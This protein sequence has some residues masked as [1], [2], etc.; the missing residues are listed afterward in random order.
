MMLVIDNIIDLHVDV[1]QRTEYFVHEQHLST[2]ASPLRSAV[3][4]VKGHRHPSIGARGETAVEVVY[5]L[6]YVL[7]YF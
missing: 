3:L 4:I 6:Q 1:V 2:K 7:L 5:S